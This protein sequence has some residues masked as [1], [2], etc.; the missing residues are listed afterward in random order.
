MIKSLSSDQI[1]KYWKDNARYDWYVARRKGNLFERVFYN[2]KIRHILSLAKFKDKQIL[3]MGCGT[4]VNTMDFYKKSKETVGIDISSW[5]VKRARKK[6]KGIKFYIRDSENTGFPDN[7]FDIIV[8]TGLIQYLKNP[9]QTADE[10]HRILKP[11]GIAIVEVP[12]RYSVYN[13]RIIRRLI[14]GQQ[15]PNDEPIN[16]TYD[17]RTLRRLFGKFNCIKIHQFLFIVL[18]GVFVKK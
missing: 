1:K 5:A 7:H 9:R 10:M 11:G 4:G 8:N 16:K 17:T 14:T 6:F 3:D 2:L 18:Y 15:N 13:S 12:W